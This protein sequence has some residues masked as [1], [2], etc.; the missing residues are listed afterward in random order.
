MRWEVLNE[1][2]IPVV[3]AGCLNV[4]FRL[5]HPKPARAEPNNQIAAGMGTM[6]HIRGQ[7]GSL[8][9]AI[10]IDLNSTGQTFRP[11]ALGIPI[12]TGECE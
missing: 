3:G 2:P 1:Q 10:L 6:L 12:V 5:N 9:V 4:C 8:F 11:A 7:C